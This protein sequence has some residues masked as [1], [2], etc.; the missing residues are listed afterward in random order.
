MTPDKERALPKAVRDVRAG[1]NA[2]RT[3]SSVSSSVTTCQRFSAS[4]YSDGHRLVV[5]AVV[6]GDCGRI[7]RQDAKECDRRPGASLRTGPACLAGDSKRCFDHS[8]DRCVGGDLLL[9][10][11]RL[12]RRVSTRLAD[13]AGLNQVTDDGDVFATAMSSETA[14]LAQVV[15]AVAAD[16]R[17]IS[18]VRVSYAGFAVRLNV[19]GRAMKEETAALHAAPDFLDCVRGHVAKHFPADRPVRQDSQVGKGLDSVA[20]REGDLFFDGAAVSDA[21]A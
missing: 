16:E 17:A 4:Q 2:R 11:E 3:M 13:V 8:F 18:C 6:F 20:V 15:L 1:Q 19:V 5:A 14:A 7:S 21:V 10:R 9:R 12:D